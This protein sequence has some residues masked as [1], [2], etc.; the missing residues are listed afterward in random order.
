VDQ[1]SRLIN[2]AYRMLGSR[3]DAEDVVQEAYVRLVSANEHEIRD[4]VGWLV[5]VTSRLCIDQLRSARVRKESYVGPW[6]PEPI[7]DS[8]ADPADRI[9]LDDSVRMAMLIVLEQLTP[10]ERVAYILHD[11]FRIPFEQVSGIV[12]RSAQACRQLASRARQRISQ[13]APPRFVV[14]PAVA[15]EVT[16][17]FARACA[18]GDLAALTALL[19]PNVRGLFDSGGHLPGAP[20]SLVTGARRVASILIRVFAGTG[21]SLVPTVLNGGPG[22][23]VSAE[24][25][26]V[27]AIS[28]EIADGLI[29]HVHGVG[30]PEKLT[31]LASPAERA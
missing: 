15:S 7:L 4:P 21:A 16:A 1:R 31:H 18:T 23:V 12:G 8:S 22:I 11:V 3:S 28:L 13:A 20:R 27:S 14:D 19:D 5:A 17:G 25:S 10:S 29:T 24:G 26:V 9:T 6:L 2:V 30:N